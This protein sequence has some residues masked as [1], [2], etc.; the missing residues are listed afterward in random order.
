MSERA[1]SPSVNGAGPS[2]RV[3]T[4]SPPAEAPPPARDAPIGG[5]ARPP[6][7]TE[8]VTEPLGSW[9]KRPRL[10]RLPVVRGVVALAESLKIGF[11]AL[12]LSANAQAPPDEEGKSEIG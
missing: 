11:K 3:P 10:L 4:P 8:A 1:T 7:G 2:E 5:P 9:T 6:G 12:G